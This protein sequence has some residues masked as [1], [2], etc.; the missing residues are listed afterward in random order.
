MEE[1]GEAK[2]YVINYKCDMCEHGYLQ[3]KELDCSKEPRVYVHEC[4]DCKHTGDFEHKY[5]RLAYKIPLAN[6]QMQ[7]GDIFL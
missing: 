3:Y 6:G 2:M 5:P 7:N 1:C 4:A